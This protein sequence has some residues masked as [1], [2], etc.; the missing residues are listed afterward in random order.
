MTAWMIFRMDRILRSLG[1]LPARPLV[2]GGVAI[3]AVELFAF[4][5]LASQSHRVVQRGRAFEIS[6]I[7]IA[8]GDTVEFSNEDEFIHQIFI[9]SQTLNIDSA[10]QSPGQVIV[11]K[12]PSAGSFDVHCHIHPKMYLKVDVN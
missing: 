7:A 3:A 12:F 2:L 4:L 1:H 8:A 6:E 10:E 5:A 9:Q 11:I